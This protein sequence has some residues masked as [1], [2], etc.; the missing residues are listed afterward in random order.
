MLPLYFFI[1]S[2]GYYSY[3]DKI[4]IMMYLI[5]LGISIAFPFIYLVLIRE[6][7]TFRKRVRDIKKQLD[8]INPTVKIITLDINVN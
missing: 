1:L 7:K 5:M 4:N 8:S 2:M 6:R 3:K